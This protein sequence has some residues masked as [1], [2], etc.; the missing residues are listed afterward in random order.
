MVQQGDEIIV[1]VPG[2]SNILY[3]HKEAFSQLFCKRCKTVSWCFSYLSPEDNTG[4]I[5]TFLI[6]GLA[7]RKLF[8]SR[9]LDTIFSIFVI[10]DFVGDI[11]DLVVL[12][13]KKFSHQI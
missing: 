2:I 10:R 9:L 12:D 7:V 3:I 4:L 1:A 8:E 13:Y 5:N 6:F 11:K